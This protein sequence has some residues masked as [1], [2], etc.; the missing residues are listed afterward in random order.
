MFG[1]QDD[2]V[3]TDPLT[4]NSS[5]AQPANDNS[6]VVGDNGSHSDSP[7]SLTEPSTEHQSDLPVPTTSDTPSLPEE[8]QTSDNDNDNVTTNPNHDLIIPTSDD[9]S[10]DPVSAP[11]DVTPKVNEPD[12]DSSTNDLLDVKKKALQELTP[13]VSHLEQPPE[14]QFRTMMMMIQASDNQ[15]LIESAY[16]AAHKITD[17]KARAQALLDVVNE[18]NYF[19]QNPSTE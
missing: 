2:Q 8:P 5:P 13:L 9:T 10:A 14:E 18:I 4:D 16:E 17:E 15:S 11:D 19:T 3:T 6:F 7:T 1:H 12:S